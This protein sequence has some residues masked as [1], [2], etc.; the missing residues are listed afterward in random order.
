MKKRSTAEALA[1]QPSPDFIEE[2]KKTVHETK[3][4]NFG[5]RK[6]DKGE[7]NLSGMY[8]DIN[9]PDSEGVL[10]TAYADFNTFLRVYEIEGERYPVKIE[11]RETSCFEEH[12]LVVLEDKCV[13]F[14][15][16]SEGIRRALV[17]LED[18]LIKSEAPFLKPLKK[19]DVR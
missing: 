2:L 9:I 6:A 1:N 19:H 15:Q 5:K 8:L 12:T 3:P 18:M 11:K 17:M 13:I 4:E 16:D 7:I 10:E 14:A